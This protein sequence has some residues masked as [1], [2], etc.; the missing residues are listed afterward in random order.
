MGAL[1]R[2]RNDTG[3][4]RHVMVWP[5]EQHPDRWPFDIGPGETTDKLPELLAGFTPLEDEKKPPVA[6]KTVPA[7][8]AQTE[9]VETP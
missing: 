1:V 7:V 2:Q 6:R 9:G 5:D 4:T 3:Y 8:P